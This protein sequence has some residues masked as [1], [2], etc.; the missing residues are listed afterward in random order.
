M[1]PSNQISLVIST[2]NHVRPLELCLDGF[3]RQS[4]QP[5]EI[6]IADD[7]SASPTR[8]LIARLTITDCP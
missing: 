4:A 1:I 3:R 8:D 7:G 2:Y 5:M 6:I